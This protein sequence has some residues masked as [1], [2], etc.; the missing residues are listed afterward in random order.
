M[1]PPILLFPLRK[2]PSCNKWRHS[3]DNSCF[4]SQITKNIKYTDIN[5]KSLEITVDDVSIK[6]ISKINNFIINNKDILLKYWNSELSSTEFAENIL[7]FKKKL[8]SNSFWFLHPFKTNE[9][10]K[11]FFG[12]RIKERKISINNVILCI[13]F[14]ISKWKTLPLSWE[15]TLASTKFR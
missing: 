2:P 3:A 9:L 4:L 6:S 10:Q 1:L 15:V 11:Y 7:K 5:I 14:R 12:N 13:T 8:R